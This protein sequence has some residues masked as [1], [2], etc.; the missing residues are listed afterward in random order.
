M[1][2]QVS[3]ELSF[4]R[5]HPQL[6]DDSGGH[7]PYPPHR[8]IGR[9]YDCSLPELSTPE[10]SARPPPPHARLCQHSSTVLFAQSSVV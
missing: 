3:L 8:V 6:V 5:H 1:G 7:Y 10:S 2:N 4:C 9:H